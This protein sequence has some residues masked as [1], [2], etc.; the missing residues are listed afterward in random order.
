MKTKDGGRVKHA[1]QII[2]N[3]KSF[4]Q[5]SGMNTL[6]PVGETNATFIDDGYDVAEVAQAPIAELLDF[7]GKIT[8]DAG[9][10]ELLGSP[11]RADSSSLI[12]GERE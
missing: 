6:Q 3:I 11:E 5:R 12:I 1:V 10:L 2:V 8:S 7:L 9:R 4:Q